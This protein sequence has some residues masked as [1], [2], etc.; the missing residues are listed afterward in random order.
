[1]LDHPKIKMFM[2]FQNGMSYVS[3]LDYYFRPNGWYDEW[4]L[5]GKRTI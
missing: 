5:G 2:S 1:M 4:G 3:Y